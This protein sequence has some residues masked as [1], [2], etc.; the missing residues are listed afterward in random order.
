VGRLSGILAGA[1]ALARL[2]VDA[3][4]VARDLRGR[5]AQ[6]EPVGDPLVGGPTEAVPPDGAHRVGPGGPPTGPESGQGGSAGLS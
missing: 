4:L 5:G 2:V 1:V 6:T 3:L